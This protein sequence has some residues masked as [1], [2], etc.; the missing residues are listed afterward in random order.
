MKIRSNKRYNIFQKLFTG[1]SESDISDGT[2]LTEPPK[3]LNV[4]SLQV[5]VSFSHNLM[6]Y[7]YRAIH[8]KFNITFYLTM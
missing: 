6:T 2:A 3:L 8:Y 4:S 1:A 5:S 7:L